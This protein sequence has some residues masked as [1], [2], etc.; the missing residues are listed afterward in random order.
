[1]AVSIYRTASEDRVPLILAA[2][3]HIV[4]WWSSRPLIAAL[5][6]F[7]GPQELQA[8][9]KKIANADYQVDYWNHT[10]L[11]NMTEKRLRQV[12]DRI[13][14][15]LREISETQEFWTHIDN[16]HRKGALP[17]VLLPIRESTNRPLYIRVAGYALLGAAREGDRDLLIRL[18]GHEYGLIA[19]SAARSLVRCFGS[20]ALELLTAQIEE[21]VARG[22]AKSIAGALAEAE[23]QLFG[24]APQI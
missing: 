14:P 4:L 1:L 3:D 7:G 17:G 13:P 23:M 15:F 6:R 12:T 10:E 11:G 21:S 22:K 20:T 19:R 9:L 16:K 5:L 18:A 2:L 8:V 24:V